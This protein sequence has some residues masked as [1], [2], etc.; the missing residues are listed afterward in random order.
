MI[1]FEDAR[2]EFF[3]QPIAWLPYFSAPDPT[4]KRKTGLLMPSISSSS[5]YGAALEVPYYWALAPDYDATFAPMITTKQG[6]LLQGEF[7]QRLINGAYSIR[8]AGIYQLDKDYFLR[9][10]G[11]YTPGYRDCRGSLESTGQFALNNKWVWGWDGAAAVRQDIPAGL[12]PAPVAIPHNRS[13]R[14]RRPAKLSRSSLSPARAIAAIS[15]PARSTTTASRTRTRKARSRSSIRCSTTTTSSIVRFS[16][17]NSATRSTSP[18]SRVR[19]P[20]SIRS[21]RAR[22]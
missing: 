1:Y 14:R 3:G 17:A 8:A 22:C 9:S 11:T 15:T 6:P 18:A 2:L 7:R 20:T 5:I 10:D 13:V 4:V 16:A 12:Q 19:M 21:P